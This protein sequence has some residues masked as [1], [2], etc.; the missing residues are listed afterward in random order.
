LWEEFETG[1]TYES[2]FAIA[3]DK[4]EVLIQHN[5]A[6]IETWEEV[7]FDFNYH[8]AVKQVSYDS[9]LTLIRGFILE[10]TFNKINRECK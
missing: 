10:D 3:L 1:E 4:L 7:E 8:Y 9:T 2:K 5:Q 6:D